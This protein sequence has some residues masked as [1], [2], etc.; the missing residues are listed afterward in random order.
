MSGSAILL[1][2]NIVM[3]WLLER[4]PFHKNSKAIIEHCIHV[5]GIDRQMLVDALA[6]ENFRDIEDGTQIQCAINA[7]LDYIVTRDFD[8][9]K[10]SKITVISPERFVDM[11][12][13]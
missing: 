8:G 6:D 9:F 11:M 13:S 12:I 3:D 2:T 1:D 5:V 4:E 7:E 10:G